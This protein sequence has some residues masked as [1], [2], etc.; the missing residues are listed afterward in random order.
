MVKAYQRYEAEKN[1]G[2][3][4]SPSSNSVYSLDGKYAISPALQDV[5]VWDL[6]K[7]Q[8]YERWSDFDN[9]SHVTCITRSPSEDSYAI[10]YSDGS[11]RLF[12]FENPS[13][14]CIFNGHKGAITALTFDPTGTVLCSGSRDTDLVLWDIIAETGL[15]RLKGHKD[16]ITGIIFVND[17]QNAVSPEK[18]DS[19]VDVGSTM[20]SYTSQSTETKDA[21]TAGEKGF[22]ITSSKDTLVKVWDLEYRH[23]VQ[24]I[25]S[26]KSEVWSIAIS[27]DHKTLITGS[28]ESNLKVFKLNLQDSPDPSV[29]LP[30][31]G[32]SLSENSYN[33]SATYSENLLENLVKKGNK[34]ILVE[35][36][37]ISKQSKERVTMLQFHPAGILLGCQ[38]NDRMVEFFTISTPEEIKKKSARK[39]KRIREKK[40]SEPSTIDDPSVFELSTQDLLNLEYLPRQV[41][42]LVAKSRS[43]MF[44]PTESSLLIVNRQKN[45]KIMF[46]LVNN[47]LSV[48]SLPI[49]SSLKTSDSDSKKLLEPQWIHSIERLG[50]RSEPRCIS[51]SSDNELIATA[52][53]SNILVWNSITKACIRTLECSQPL[54]VVFLPGDQH[55]AVGT[56][57]GTIELFDLAAAGPPIATY[58]AHE[59][60][61]YCIAVTPDKSGIVS[62]GGDKESKFWDF[63]MISAAL[64]NNDDTNTPSL[65]VGK[66]LSLVH[67]RTLKLP[68]VVLSVVVS[69]NLKFVAYSL[70]DTT[71]KV[72]F[73]DSLK[74]SLSLYGH[75]LPALS[76]DISSDSTLL[77]SGSADK[78]V[79]IWGLDF[80]DCHKSIYAHKDAITSVK[81]VWDTHYFFSAGKDGAV[82]MWDA[83]KF[84]K[85]QSLADG[86]FSGGDIWGLAV[87]KYGNFIAAVSQDR[88]IRIW[89]KTEEPLF[90]EEE[91]E[92]ELEKFH[93]QSMVADAN[94]NI[95]GFEES[96]VAPD[97]N[98][99]VHST[100]GD[101]ENEENDDAVAQ[102]SGVKVTLENMKAG[103]KI[104]EAIKV[105]E[106]ELQKRD[107][108]DE[109]LAKSQTNSMY[110]RPTIPPPNV[111]LKAMNISVA[112]VRR[113]VDAAS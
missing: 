84:V 2:V 18:S 93:E 5:M 104:I 7:G 110:P 45:T 94:K 22:L 29:P 30:S 11:I 26:H 4:C 76:I 54:T 78:N 20:D 62:G 85:I 92:N 16:Q 9:N 13:P 34:E 21:F 97:S 69:P 46:A 74:F 57:S 81:F 90:L 53:S 103:E 100:R 82:T 56:K 83:D 24:T 50:H 109:A 58:E 98:V 23:C 86:G 37:F 28:S 1:F 75:K 61:V 71:I 42:R 52:C 12:D 112:E 88:S 49:I 63:E 72:F 41:L 91:R 8:L 39:I 79:K 51:L 47:S 55:L 64:A 65:Q 80:G 111:L 96:E 27:P 106:L 68:D 67:T 10:G 59:G 40:S 77:V 99:L 105:V 15:Y 31:S 33:N 95:S 101:Q 25:V 70:L 35:L 107:A 36:G 44:N 89:N 14:S 108:Y 113:P 3:I 87:A 102:V 43:F 38:T 19:V 6:K 60:G 48:A 32:T 17:Q 66:T 73:Y